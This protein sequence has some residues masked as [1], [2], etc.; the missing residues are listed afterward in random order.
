MPD[1]Y[2]MPT[3]P[4]ND[5][6]SIAGKIITDVASLANPVLGRLASAGLLPGARRAQPKNNESNN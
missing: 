2:G 4:I 5:S 1:V 3:P 6:S